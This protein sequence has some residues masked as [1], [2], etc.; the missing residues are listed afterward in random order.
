MISYHP[1]SAHA[2]VGTT[3]TAGFKVADIDDVNRLANG[4]SAYAWSPCQWKNGYRSKE[5]FTK[6]NWFAL[7]FDTY[8]LPLAQAVRSFSDMIHIIGTTRNHQKDKDGV[9][10]DRFRVLIKAAEV[11]TDIRLFESNLRRL[12]RKYPID[13]SCVDGAR[14]FFRCR[15]II[16][17][18]DDGYTEDV[19]AIKNLVPLSS[20]EYGEELTNL[21]VDF[22]AR[23]QLPAWVETFLKVGSCENRHAKAYGVVINLVELGMPLPEILE[24]VAKAPISRPYR[25]GEVEE[26]IQYAVKLV[27]GRLLGGETGT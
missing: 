10:C 22:A 25:P 15:E 16:S 4:V 24:R 3:F 20:D 13:K 26:M 8:E 14:H 17:I 9:T 5:N 21:R 27:K 19:E 23:G 2:P 18:C 6:A 12:S 7:D 11:M 1:D